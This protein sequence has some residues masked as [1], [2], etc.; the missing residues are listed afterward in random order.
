M[1]I[2][3][4]MF[5]FEW[6]VL[7][8]KGLM[9]AIRDHIIAQTICRGITPVFQLPRGLAAGTG[10]RI[11]ATGGENERNNQKKRSQNFHG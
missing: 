5:V 1:D 9:S 8:M 6:Q 4:C 7:Q 11:L 3:V 2:D 10:Q